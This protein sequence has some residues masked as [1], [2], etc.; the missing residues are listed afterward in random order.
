MSARA[1]NWAWAQ[2]P[3]TVSQH[4]VLAALGDRA[5]E[6]GYCFPSN[7][8]VAEKCWPMPKETVRRVIRELAAQGLL[9]KEE[10][11]R[12]EDGTLSTWLLRLPVNQRAL[13]NGSPACTGDQNQRAPMH[14][15]NRTTGTVREEANASS[16]PPDVLW[17]RLVQIIG[18]EPKTKSE[19]G[20]WNHALKEMRDAQ[21]TPD[22]LT[23]V[24][25]AYRKTWPEMTMTPTALVANWT[26]LTANGTSSKELRAKAFLA[27]KANLE[28]EG[29]T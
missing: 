29:K 23:Q 19:R 2:K 21:A 3:K 14:A 22:Q 24:A 16:R 8:W 5:D 25:L 26:V 17:D 11:R 9:V 4:F 10:R 13:V 15:Q 18:E 20:R 12:R 27:H 1:L 28:R 7:E 6:D